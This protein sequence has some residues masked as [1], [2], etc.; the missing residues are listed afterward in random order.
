MRAWNNKLQVWGSAKKRKE[1]HLEPANPTEEGLASLHSIIYRKDP[2][3]W[4]CAMLYY[5]VYQVSRHVTDDDSGYV[6][7]QSHNAFSMTCVQVLITY[8]NGQVFILAAPLTIKTDQNA[9]VRSIT[10]YVKCYQ[11]TQMSFAEVF[12]DLGRFVKDPEVR[13]EYCIRAK[14]GQFDT[15]IP[16]AEFNH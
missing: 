8:L 11:A 14:R 3:L 12:S 16:G 9:N 7:I 4:R 10:I 2:C 6:V 13:W 5:T 15:S 1:H